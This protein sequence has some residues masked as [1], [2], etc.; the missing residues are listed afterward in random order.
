MFRVVCKLKEVKHRLKC[1]NHTFC[2]NF[3]DRAEKNASQ[4]NN[5]EE[6]LVV[7]P[8]NFRLINWHA[9]LIKQRERLLLFN[10][11]YWGKFYRK[12]W[13]TKGD[14]NSNF[15]YQC[16]KTRKWRNSILRIKDESRV[17][18]DDKSLIE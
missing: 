3:F 13:L 7:D 10:Q 8:L 2:S 6:K 9:C 16:V 11:K 15:F 5:V 4:L 1:W 14:R 12:E 18:F 17:W